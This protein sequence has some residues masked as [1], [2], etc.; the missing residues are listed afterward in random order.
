MAPIVRLRDWVMQRTCLFALKS[1]IKQQMFFSRLRREDAARKRKVAKAIYAIPT[2]LID[3]KLGGGDIVVSL[4]SYGKRV[5]DALPYML[6][7]ICTQTVLPHK[8][9]VYLDRDHWNDETLPPLLKEMQR[10]GVVGVQHRD[11]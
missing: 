5:G 9:V 11:Y 7:S 4:T 8:V 2:S 10:V 3:G 1:K 6:Y